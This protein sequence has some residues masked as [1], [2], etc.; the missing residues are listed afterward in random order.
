MLQCLSGMYLFGM[1]LQTLK[2][3]CLFTLEVLMKNEYIYAVQWVDHGGPYHEPQW[4]EQIPTVLIQMGLNPSKMLLELGGLKI[5]NLPD[6]CNLFGYI[7]T[8]VPIPRLDGKYKP[9]P[10]W[11]ES[12]QLWF[13]TFEPRKED[14][15]ERYELFDFEDLFYS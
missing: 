13:H 6:G 12:I 9:H 8:S 1:F 15:E 11:V 4:E 10:R 5:K 2:N 14:I 3:E 7:K